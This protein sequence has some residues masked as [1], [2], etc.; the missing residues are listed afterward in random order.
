LPDDGTLQGTDSVSEFN[1][2]DLAALFAANH[3]GSFSADLALEVVLHEIAEQACLATGATGTAIVLGREGEMVCR[4]SSGSTAPELGARLDSSSGITGECLRS[5]QVQRCDDAQAD[6]RADVEASLRLGI[7]SVMVSPLVR[8]SGLV[9]LFEVFS[10]RTSAFGERDERT[11]EAL[12]R[13]VIKNLE[14]ADQAP[15]GVPDPPPLAS[16]IPPP[17]RA[18]MRLPPVKEYFG[19]SAPKTDSRTVKIVTWAL[20]LTV[21]ACA[22]LLGTLAVQRLGGT[23]DVTHARAAKPKSKVGHTAR[24]ESLQGN[25]SQ[26]GRR[27]EATSPSASVVDPS[28]KKEVG[29]SSSSAGASPAQSSSSHQAAAQDSSL[30]P[31]SLRVYE[32]GREVFRMPASQGQA[33]VEKP[34]G[35]GVQLAASVNHEGTMEL[36]PA[37]AEDSLI[38]RVEPD[39]PEQALQQKIQGP[40]VL[41]VRINQRGA[42]Q[43]LKLVSGPPLLAQAAM[44]AVKQWQFKPRKVNGHLAEMQ[45]KITLNFKLPN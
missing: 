13:R 19:E 22:L 2:A 11:L 16:P 34:A 4:A 39:Y 21:L 32:N 45:T 5:L 36:S 20:G 7:R 28:G 9:G 14:S 37:A 17:E 27:S 33:V 8:D 26:G 42:V 18:E 3:G 29:S 44:D 23:G 24:V 30:P 12:A 10:T 41:D 6:P 25:P 1:L 15:S 31:G 38:H 40:V 43:E 35:S